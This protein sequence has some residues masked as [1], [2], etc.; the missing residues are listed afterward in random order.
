[1]KLDT[2]IA[3]DK[4]TARRVDEQGFLHVQHSN[5][6]KSV[7]NPY[8]GAEIPSWQQHGLD[9]QKVYQI[10]R[11]AE[12][13]KK[14]AG[15]FNNL[16]LMD[17]HIEVSAFDLENPDVKKHVVGSTGQTAEF[18][19][20][21]LTNDLVVWTAGAIEGINSRE[22][23]EL[24]CAYRYEL[25]LIPG[26]FE[27]KHYDGRMSQIVGN[28]V[29]LVEEGRA[30]P[31]VLVADAAMT[32]DTEAQ[33]IITKLLRIKEE[34]TEK[35]KP[36]IEGSQ[37]EVLDDLTGALDV[38]IHHLLDYEEAD[39]ITVEEDEN[40]EGIN[41]YTG[42]G[43]ASEHTSSSAASASAKAI[44]VEK[45]AAKS[46]S[47]KLHENARNE[48]A[49]AHHAHVSAA[50]TASASMKP[51]HEHMAKAHSQAA[52]AH[53]AGKTPGIRF[54]GVIGG[55]ATGVHDSITVEED[56]NPEGIN[57]YTGAASRA[58]AAT[59]KA[60]ATSKEADKA[61][62][63]PSHGKAQVAHEKA[64][65]H[66][67]KAAQAHRDAASKAPSAKEK[68]DHSA[69]A[70]HHD[71]MSERHDKRAVGHNMMG[72]LNGTIHDSITA[73]ADDVA[74]REDVNPKQGITKYGEV[75]FA[76]PKNKKYPL[77]TPE[78]VRS[79]ASYWGRPKNKNK[80]SEAD[81]AAITKRID[82]AEK[83]FKLGQYAEKSK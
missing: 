61:S 13:L 60:A 3:F 17:V 7:V 37:A 69:K 25:E 44:K 2:T 26:E 77:D 5:I 41:Q 52:E 56:E 64:A 79:A 53:A 31:D 14:A 67:E 71:K 47:A 62:K 59:G 22:Q 10:L 55:H 51:W 15:T 8:M 48:H 9:P 24:S 65:A 83:K 1:M 36:G 11:P 23:V 35:L 50:K 49:A 42:G 66:H 57:Q 73:Y 20:P 33:D 18:N 30:G 58:S 12:E 72:R 19:D 45:A 21:Y 6:S 38:A 27:G 28:H 32:N 78:H 70:V 74:K 80:Y 68:A 82:S 16:P 39:S 29:A 40:P 76:D 43:G 34:I 81:K 46:G 4:A 54:P 75:A 63:S